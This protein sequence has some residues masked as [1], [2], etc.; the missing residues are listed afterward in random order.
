MSRRNPALIR[1]RLMPPQQL[2][3]RQGVRSV[4][5]LMRLL[6][7]EAGTTAIEYAL[8]ASLIAVSG[9]AAYN[10]IGGKT[11]VPFNTVANYLGG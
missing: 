4:K 2:C 10:S 9:I 6:R 1:S 8:V 5:F 7:H 3:G 11:D